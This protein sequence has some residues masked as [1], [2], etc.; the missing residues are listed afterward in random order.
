MP[1]SREKLFTFIETSR[2]N[3]PWAKEIL[4]KITNENYFLRIAFSA[5]TMVLRVRR[6]IKIII[7]QIHTLI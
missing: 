1:F 3:S 2:T 4:A 6:K 7:I 5:Q